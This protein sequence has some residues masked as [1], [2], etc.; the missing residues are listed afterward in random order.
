[1]RIDS[2]CRC[3]SYKH[4][5]GNRRVDITKLRFPHEHA[6]DSSSSTLFNKTYYRQVLRDSINDSRLKLLLIL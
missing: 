3:K 4:R 1:M 2:I 6:S 5:T